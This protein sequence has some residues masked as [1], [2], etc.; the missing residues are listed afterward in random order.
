M[1]FRSFGTGS[2]LRDSQV[3]P[4]NSPSTGMTQTG[5]VRDARPVPSAYVLDADAPPFVDAAADQ[6]RAAVVEAPGTT[7]T[8]YLVWSANTADLAGPTNPDP[9]WWTETGYGRIPVDT[10]TV[11]S[12]TDGST[13]ALVTDKGNKDIGRIFSIV[14]ARGDVSDYVDEGWKDP[15][16][17]NPASYGG[18]ARKGD[19]PYLTLYFEESKQDPRLGMVYLTDAH[20]TALGGGLSLDRGDQIMVVHYTVS[21]ARF[22][23]SKND[24]YESRFGWAA[25]SRRWEPFK[26]TSPQNLG[27]LKNDVHSYSMIPA[28]RNLPAGS[29]LPH[30]AADAY[31]M[32]RVGPSPSA[33]QSV[34]VAGIVVRPDNET[35]TLIPAAYNGRMGQSNGQ[36]EFSLDFTAANLGK[37]VW[38]VPN[39]FMATNDGIVG[40]MTAHE[41][42]IA[43]VPSLTEM[44]LIRFGSRKYLTA[45]VV[46]T[47]A[48]L[49][50][51]TAPYAGNVL[52]S[53]A[54]GKLRFHAADLA[55]ANPASSY[56]SKHFLGEVVVYDGVSLSGIEQPTRAPVQLLD[57]AGASALATSSE[58]YIP[59]YVYLPTEFV[60]SNT[61]RGLGT[62]GVLD[63]PDGT[64]AVPDQ[65]GVPASLRPGGDN[66]ADVTTGRVRQVVDGISDTILFT[67]LGSVESIIVVD[68]DSGV[69]SQI[70][71]GKAYVVRSLGAHGS[72]VYLSPTDVETFGDKPIFFLQA[73]FNPAYHTT[74]ARLVS[75]N[76]NIFRFDG[77][78]VLRFAIDGIP[79]TWVS[80]ALVAA[81]PSKTYFTTDEVVASIGLST[82]YASAERIVIEAANPD[83]GSV[84][85]GFGVGGDLDLSGCKILGF[86][87]GWRAVGG[88]DNWLPDSGVSMGMYRTPMDPMGINGTADFRATDRVENQVLI[89]GIQAMP[90][91][92]LNTVPLQDIAGIEDGIFFN[93]STTVTNGDTV[94]IVNKNL[95]HYK[96]IIHR[97]TRKKF[98]W[99]QDVTVDG[100]VH[101]PTVTLN[102]GHNGIAP[103]SFES[104]VG[105]GLYVSRDG[106]AAT[107]LTRN[108]DYIIP[109]DGVAGNALLIK[110]FFGQVSFGSNGSTTSGSNVFSDPN[111]D[112]STTTAK[113]G[114]IL[115]I[116]GGDAKGLYTVTNAT[117]VLEV[118]PTPTVA[119]TSTW[120]LYAGIP[121]S[122]LDPAL[123][124]DM[125]YMDFDHLPQETMTIRILSPV[126]VPAI[127]SS[128]A[129]TAL[130]SGALA[131]GRKMAFR[132]GSA[133]PST[134]TNLIP[135]RIIDLGLPHNGLVIPDT[136]EP[137]FSAGKF[138]L[139]SGP[140]ETVSPQGV[141]IFSSDPYNIEYLTQDTSEGVKGTLKFGS[142]FMAKWSNI[143]V[144]Y[145]DQFLD[146]TQ[147]PQGSAEYDPLTGD[148]MPSMGDIGPYLADPSIGFYF[149][150]EMITKARKDVAINPILGAFS[151]N[152]PLVKGSLVEVSY[153]QADLEG[154]KVGNQINEFLP[155][156]VRNEVAVST[157][158]NVYTFNTALTHRIDQAI[159]PTVYIG[160]I[161][162]NY[163]QLD[164]ILDYPADLKGAGQITFVS[165]TVDPNVDVKVSYAVFDM[166]GGERSFEV[167]TKPV[168]RPPFYIGANQNRF[169]L[170]GDRT[171]EFVPGQMLR[172]GDE[173]FYVKS[174]KYYPQNATNTGDVT[175]VYIFP[176]TIAEV[177]SRAPGNDVLTVITNVP[178]TTVVDPD[179]TTPVVTTAPNG[180][181]WDAADLNNYS[182]FDPIVRGQKTWTVY[183]PSGSWPAGTILEVGGVPYTIAK[184]E[185]DE[186]GSRVLITV[187]SAF[188]TNLTMAD[189]PTIKITNRP[190]YPPGAE[191][192]L[193]V[194]AILTTELFAVGIV[195]SAAPGR[196]L[197]TDV[198]CSIDPLTGNIHIPGGITP[199]QKIMVNFTRLDSM[200]PSMMNGALMTPW[201]TASF[202]AQQFPDESNGILNGKL[203][204]TYSFSSPDAFYF[205]AV[206]LRT[207]VGEVVE[208][209]SS[210]IA[211][212]QPA[213]GALNYTSGGT[214]NW[215]NGTWDLLGERR[216]LM[217]KDR[218]ARTFLEYYNNVIVAFEQVDETISGG[219]V[220]DRDG[221]FHFW[222]GHDNEW[223]KPGYEDSITG[224]LTTHFVWTDIVNQENP[225]AQYAG[226]LTDPVVDPST[227]NVV[228]GEVTGSIV[229]SNKLRD[230][231][232]KQ[233]GLVFND[234]D[235]VVLVSL[236]RM[237]LAFST[238]APYFSMT[239]QGLYKAMGDE[240][241]MSRLF[242]TL[243]KA[244]IRTLPGIGASPGVYSAGVYNPVSGE[245]ESTSGSSIAQLRNP[246]IGDIT[247]VSGANL[248]KRRARARIW[249]WFP[250]GLPSSAFGVAVAAPC[251][252]AVPALLRDIPIVPETGY[253]DPFK[254][255]S[256]WPSG[257]IPDAKAGDPELAIPGFETGDQIAWG[258]PDGT[259]YPAYNHLDPI[260]INSVDTYTGIFVESVLH[261]CV[262]TFQDVHGV[263]IMDPNAI[264]AGSTSIT[265]LPI[266]QG[267]TI[268][269]GA[270]TASFTA[271]P[272]DPAEFSTMQSMTAGMDT[273]RDGF[274][275]KVAS[276][277]TLIDLSLPSEADGTYLYLKELFGQNAPK[278]M[279]A[280]EGPVFFALGNQNPLQVPA[281]QGKVQDDSGDYQIPYL[282]SVNTEMDRF[283]EVS[284]GMSVVY[285]VDDVGHSMY[286]D[287]IVGDDGFISVVE[288]AR[289]AALKTL[290]FMQ[291]AYA[292]GVAPA[293]SF[294]LVLTQ[295]S[296]TNPFST[297]GALG[298][299]TM[300]AVDDTS[301]IEPPRFNTPTQA[302]SPGSAT[303]DD[304]TYIVENAAVYVDGN[305]PVQ[306]Q[307][308]PPPNGVY[309]IVDVPNNRT[310]LDFGTTTIALNDGQTIGVGNLNYLRA[311]NAEIT[312]KMIARQDADIVNGP[313]G[314]LPST[315]PGGQVALTFV[316]NAT[317][318]SVTDYN[319]GIAGA[320][321]VTTVFGTH[322]GAPLA[323]VIN[324]RQIIIPSAIGINWGP[325]PGTPAQWFLPHT[326][327]AGPVYTML[328]GFEYS[329]SVDMVTPGIP[330]ASDTA[331][332]SEDRLTFNEVY[333]L[334]MSKK[335]GYTHPQ[336]GIDLETKLSIYDVTVGLTTV[337]TTASSINRWCNGWV[338]IT[339]IPYT[340]VPRTDLNTVGYW[341]PRVGL[342]TERGHLKVMAYE[343]HGN[344]PITM[345]GDAT[346]SVIPSDDRCVLGPILYGRGKTASRYSFLTN[347][348]N[349]RFDNRITEIFVGGGDEDR[350]EKGDIVAI[351]GSANTAH[352]GSH[353]AGTY[354]VR[355]AVRADAAGDEYVTKAPVTYAGLGSGWCP[356]HFPT[357]VSFNS[358][359]QTLLIS[360]EAPADGGPGGSGF[361]VAV[362]GV[363]RIYIVRS[364][365]D[366]TS[367][368]AH[369]FRYAVISA[370]YTAR[371]GTA[372][373]LT[374]YKDAKGIG[375]SAAAFEALLDK[376]YQVSGM[377]YWPV[378]VSGAEYGL[379]DNNCVGFDSYSDISV[380]HV[381][382]L[383]NWAI[384]GFHLLSFVPQG[385]LAS[386]TTQS[387]TADKAVAPGAYILKV[388]GTPTC[389]VPMEGTLATTYQF[390]A[391]S[392]DPV[393]RWVVRTLNV[394][395]V[396]STQWEPLNIIPTSPFLG[397][398]L[399]NCILPGTM[400]TLSAG[401]N[402]GYFAQTGIFL[403][404][405]FPRSSLN[406][407]ATNAR[408]VDA[409]RSLPD[410]AFIPDR[411]RE[412]GMRDSQ[413]YS[414]ALVPDEVAF[415]VRRIR[416]F[417]EVL[418]KSD[419][420]LMALRFAYEIRR[421][422]IT[423]YTMD[424]KQMGQVSAIGFTWTDGNTYTGTQLGTFANSDVNIHAGDIFRVLD[425]N[426]HVVEEVRISSVKSTG[427]LVLDAPGLQ[428]TITPGTT[429]FQVFLKKA[430]VPHEQSG[431]EL[432][433]IITDKR[434]CNTVANRTTQKGG[435]VPDIT[436]V[437]TY[438]NA[439]NRLYDDLNAPN[440]GDFA[441][442]GI[443]KGDIIIIDPA[444]VIPLDGGLPTP[445]EHGRRPLG[446]EGVPSRTDAGVYVAGTPSPLDDNRGFYRVKAVVDT[447]NPPYLSVTP[448]NTYAGDETTPVVFAADPYAYAVYPTVTDSD[449]KKAPYPVGN[450][451]EAQMALR[452]TLLRDAVTKSFV[453]RT[454]GFVGH[455]IRPF[456]YRI[457]RPTKMLSDPAI[458]LVLMMRERMLSLI[459]LLRYATLGLKHGSYFVF[460][461]DKHIQE[462]G[463][464]TDPDIGLGV[465]SNLFLDAVGGRMG[466]TPYANNSGCLSILDRRVWV[467]DTR[468]DSL[469]TD[470]HGG[471]KTKGLGDVAYTAYTDA[472]GSKV[473]PALPERIDQVLDTRDKLRLLRYV[474]LSYRTH[475]ILG[476]LAS[477]RRFDD[478]FPQRL[479]DQKKSIQA[480]TAADKAVAE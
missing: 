37:T 327:A 188:R 115:Y 27:V 174:L 210:E 117:S 120:N 52:V 167:S 364:I 350:V 114:D 372:F 119:A 284:I 440:T 44:P 152:A 288:G 56:F 85:I 292:T 366:L 469:T 224:Y 283:P 431:E 405:T 91:Y 136:T 90:F 249:G 135:L 260:I 374:D 307:A 315:A 397:G 298:I 155:V 88:I 371:L 196:V 13:V 328:Y 87:P 385:A 433:E 308:G 462:V 264:F 145:V 461:R 416:R 55:R 257:T 138:I 231:I 30:G 386:A 417:H 444:G 112:F 129:P 68:N 253:P 218:V 425:A 147:I 277:G 303:T 387:W 238:S 80:A 144:C 50:A 406:P 214:K 192:F 164:Y 480:V 314:V 458:D 479:D 478:T 93:L 161:R 412:M 17:T 11:G 122:D 57:A 422:I 15:N 262:I 268:F 275:V 363:T 476:T 468:L 43:P 404:P 285:G 398:T 204:G 267:A 84:E 451:K 26:G 165:H 63:V 365:N 8:E 217:D 351:T 102:L 191:D 62:S 229:S 352:R 341:T 194:G 201:Y 286:P 132:I 170:K 59:A 349:Q 20:L 67:Q 133:P 199:T 222:V 220:G 162:Q 180:L 154:R 83:T 100:H 369:I 71:G 302:P 31:G 143:N 362:P 157:R 61:R 101:A 447:A 320:L 125:T 97:F 305:Y 279:D 28:I 421:G 456:S 53:A 319:G 334:S 118:T 181:Q 304:M 367:S 65:V 470:G 110:R 471:M 430:P 241:R 333:D 326:V 336:S 297:P 197:V 464:P 36:L 142:N 373:T 160:P 457:I 14:V 355:H 360:D 108:T 177:G 332:I 239:I 271:A 432:L 379:P 5:V 168:Y 12:F 466:V 22:W 172:I 99:V 186:T 438:D 139:Q 76:R 378:N 98:D 140:H 185:S 45:M 295:I 473:L 232:R 474:W 359:T 265:N 40:P 163:G 450:G 39:T 368:T 203:A 348:N 58:L 79:R 434:I 301:A 42:F 391:D 250:D 176:P 358:G 353:Q 47:D 413:S 435:Y 252:I 228:A 388:A 212:K 21:S 402:D 442:L 384:F 244:L 291:P 225:T 339:P 272:A 306:P 128:D 96:D 251:V 150:E 4:A 356:L 70:P 296:G 230:L 278:P 141:T 311:N 316:I 9:S 455:S 258:Q 104:A 190:V 299:T 322:T 342:T 254:F 34:P 193:G 1:G 109:Q 377:T 24:R 82:V 337:S 221:K 263:T 426:G 331:W 54:T 236:G 344:T 394:S 467:H 399:V 10:E 189:H 323:P 127:G 206:P 216:A 452:P 126:T 130:M 175:A 392:L 382:P 86:V 32:I 148:F 134:I 259:V 33:A 209:I 414:T 459:E 441:T 107:L 475:K 89:D 29:T 424:N 411:E 419:Q 325:G 77:T 293:K 463:S 361:P 178:I 345:V 338:G 340:F 173:C 270:P 318:V 213:S 215:Q 121:A 436:G 151:V 376:P 46:A 465:P 48:E 247:N 408:I 234:V 243:T 472:A 78:E 317:S 420:N 383:A 381:P 51:A 207:F 137:R 123:V 428:T 113:I 179:G 211:G 18:Q 6:Y 223:P 111:V 3:A 105:G 166:S 41:L 38:Y 35:M 227:I 49:S 429:Q 400:L 289:P 75:R 7:P 19:N 246:V 66:T 202:L 309:L 131:N 390:Q 477:I 81:N 74:K 208:E 60:S 439:V 335:R 330:Y 357:V 294:D 248:H 205:R 92:F 106:E 235:D 343:G 460:Q 169:G 380:P 449:L 64:G 437:V 198:D 445:Q 156:F 313:G 276:D 159:E 418:D 240:H 261:G 346:F 69:P 393:Y 290:R 375:M 2:V 269:V 183:G 370:N 324:N 153:W 184:F 25:Q 410:P 226:L 347:Y 403:E 95:E 146:P 321:F 354:L 453:H 454:D 23:W 423:A 171:T 149:V 329:I 280:L 395:D 300:G 187:T 158:S 124:A 72:R 182:K 73:A 242:P 233:R 245:T 266:A 446:D 427:L 281:L 237:A 443:K 287:E 282:R 256:Q 94:T 415:T 312:I 103:E 389:V 273:Y 219:F 255:I 401:G 200:A 407:V 16:D 448:I 409:T 195:D 310:I 116:M 274:D 396:D